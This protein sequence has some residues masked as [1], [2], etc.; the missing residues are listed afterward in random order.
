MNTPAKV[1]VYTIALNEEANVED[2]FKSAFEADVVLIADTGS[3]DATVEAARDF[4]ID[5]ANIA[6]TPW[7]FDDARNAALAALPNDIDMCVSL[8][9][10]ERLQP[11]WY[12]RVQ[13]ARELNITRP[14]YRYVWNWIDGEPGV[15]YL[16]DKI[17]TRYGYRWKSPAHEFLVPYAIVERRDFVEGI[18]IHQHADD[19]KDRSQYLPLL[20]QAVKEDPDNDRNMH[21]LGREWMNVGN[22]EQ[23]VIIL[24][25]HLM[26]PSAVWDAERAA[27]MRYI[28]RSVQAVLGDT[29]EVEQWLLRACGEAPGYREP[30]V[31]LARYYLR[32]GQQEAAVGAAR[33]GLSIVDRE[34]SY[35]TEPDSWNGTLE[36]IAEGRAS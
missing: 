24:K 31:D 10:D 30:W 12:E 35:I 23:A 34:L 14:S 6:I 29:A 15:T 21:Y 18:E 33:R 27:S 7:R 1:A 16:A 11:G 19:T 22:Y 25:T 13:W 26:M 8:D 5:V 9:M 2:W 32:T 20:V 28:A 4:G 36:A 3:T 17:H